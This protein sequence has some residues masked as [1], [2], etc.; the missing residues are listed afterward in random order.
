M[1][2]SITSLNQVLL[3]GLLERIQ[4]KVHQ[5][6][7]GYRGAKGK[8]TL[9]I[10]KAN[11]P[12]AIS[13][14]PIRCG[15]KTFN[16]LFS[17]R[18]FV[19]PLLLDPYNGTDSGP[20]FLRALCDQLRAHPFFQEYID[21][22]YLYFNTSTDIGGIELEAKIIGIDYA[23]GFDP[24]VNLTLESTSQ[25][26]LAPNGNYPNN[27][28]AKLIVNLYTDA[29]HNP[30][31]ISL[32]PMYANAKIDKAADTGTFDFLELND[33]IRP[34]LGFDVPYNVWVP[35]ILRALS[36]TCDMSVSTINDNG[37]SQHGKVIE[38]GYSAFNVFTQTGIDKLSV[39][40]F[41]SRNNSLWFVENFE[42]VT[43]LKSLEFLTSN[44]PGSEGRWRV[45]F[46]V[47]YS[48]NATAISFYDLY[49]P[50]DTTLT[51]PTG[52]LQNHLEELEP[53]KTAFKY[54][55]S[56][57]LFGTDLIEAY[58]YYI[59]HRVFPFWKQFV[60]Q[61]SMGNPDTIF[62]HG[63]YKNNLKLKRESYQLAISD[64][65][66][67]TNGTWEVTASQAYDEFLFRSGW[68]LDK[69][70]LDRWKK[71]LSSLYIAMVPD[72]ILRCDYTEEL[73]ATNIPVQPYIKM[74]VA[75]DSIDIRE[76]NDFLY[77]VQ[78]VL[79]KAFEDKNYTEM[80]A[81][82]QL[83][84]DSEI[85]F[86]VSRTSLAGPAEEVGLL[87]QVE[88]GGYTEVSINGEGYGG[89]TIDLFDNEVLHFVVKAYK[90][91]RLQLQAVNGNSTI[92]FSKIETY[93]LKI[94]VLLGFDNVLELLYQRLENLVRL[95]GLVINTPNPLDATR[96]FSQVLKLKQD[97]G[98]LTDISLPQTTPSA[99]G[100]ELVDALV[101]N[102][103]LTIITL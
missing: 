90:L 60:F 14:L 42:K 68:L 78:F 26:V 45:Q 83:Y 91:K 95:E 13:E 1:S 16:F 79:R 10:D 67:T 71:F 8:V 92:S 99:L 29:L 52:W 62:L 73:N 66:S 88:D 94:L 35:F 12:T 74:S 19:N 40:E 25:A 51:I 72:T 27:L 36:L 11:F 102:Y 77:S 46:E 43:T 53:S 23:L 63:A 80:P 56:L 4:F 47:H 86:N 39:I 69:N 22:R 55:V 81:R 100:Y 84:F 50:F 75:S 38:R 98:K 31:Q 2:F 59:D 37:E 64:I 44:L 30:K 3:V 24:P 87:L 96:I 97:G 28:T 48:D 20:T 58:T 32:P 54:T 61:N 5:V 85:C 57:I 70:E 41:F 15:V 33:A 76:E 7:G 9:I 21:V 6:S 82:T 34:L 93:D 17:G 65:T 49:I 18:D 101:D 89:G 103:L